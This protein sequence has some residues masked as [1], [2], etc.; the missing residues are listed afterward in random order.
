MQASLTRAPAREDAKDDAVSEEM[1]M[2]GA[3]ADAQWTVTVFHIPVYDSSTSRQRERDQLGNFIL[4]GAYDE[5]SITAPPPGRQERMFLEFRARE[6]ER[7]EVEREDVKGSEVVEVEEEVGGAWDGDVV[8][9]EVMEGLFARTV[10][11]S[12]AS[13]EALWADLFNG[14]D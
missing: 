1:D 5:L 3:G 13:E 2:I 14:V 8:G 12:E 9:D 10:R 4:V 11:E 6:K 7:R